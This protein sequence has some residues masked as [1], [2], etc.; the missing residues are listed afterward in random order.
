MSKKKFKLKKTQNIGAPDAETDDILFDVFVSIDNLEEIEDVKCHKSILIG[1]TGTGKSAIIKH[2]L[3]NCENITEIAPEAMSLRYLSNSTILSYFKNL[4][5]NLNLFYKVL[6]KHVFI[7]EL[8]KMYFKEEDSFKKDTFFSNLFGVLSKEKKNSKRERAIKYL[9]EW[10]DDFWEKT[11]YRVQSIENNLQHKFA[12]SLGISA[13]V[14]L[15][16]IANE[17][18]FEEKTTVEVK[19]KAESIIYESQ[20]TELIDIVDIMKKELF[21]DYQK[22]FYIVVDDLDQ[23]WVGDELRYELIGA[24]IEVI[25]E[26]RQMKG[27]KIVICLRE[28]LNEIVFSGLTN[29]G[30]QREKFKPLFSTLTWDEENLTEFLNKRLKILSSN[31][32]DIKNAFHSARRGKITGMD[33][34]LLRTFYRP[35]DIISYV[36]HAIENSNNKDY[37]TKDI[38]A[39]AE[40]S[41]SLDRFHALED[42]WS[43][44]YGNLSLIC[45]FLRG[46]NDGFKLRS[47]NEDKLADIYLME[48]VEVEREFKGDLKRAIVEWKNGNINLQSFLKKLLYILFRVGV[49]GIKKGPTYKTAFYYTREELVNRNDVTNSSKFYVHPSLYSY[50][51]INTMAQMPEEDI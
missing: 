37:F 18:S 23:D 12:E 38:L 24:M 47:L 25:K 20:A 11:A 50:F 32:L 44:N 28:N 4:G 19:H 6:W 15:A 9:E 3:K 26:F 43:E 21:Q 36:N 46:I 16:K 10:S 22:K 48:E 17:E 5:V 35:R 13:K 39:K 14:L 33:Y 27:V 7:V 41:Y 29:K 49:I 2:L 30:G 31:E 40:P 1:R 34:V 8:L 51:K 45:E 42:E